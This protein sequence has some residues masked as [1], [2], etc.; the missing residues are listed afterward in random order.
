M[1]FENLIVN[2]SIRRQGRVKYK[3]SFLKLGV[4]CV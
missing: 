3:F 4:E 1:I 2:I